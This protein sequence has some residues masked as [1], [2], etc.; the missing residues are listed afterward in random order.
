MKT[1]SPIKRLILVSL[2][3]VLPVVYSGSIVA[4]QPDAGVTAQDILELLKHEGVITPEQADKVANIANNRRA[5]ESQAPVEYTDDANKDIPETP[6][7]GVTRIPYIPKY[8]RNEIR[9]TVRLGLREDVL[10]DVMTQARNES[11][12]VPGTNPDWTKAIKI[13]GDLRTRYQSDQFSDGNFTQYRDYNAI[14]ARGGIVPAGIDAFLNTTENR[15]RLRLRL[16]LG[17]DAQVTQGVLASVRLTTGGDNPVSSNQTLG[18]YGS[19][20]QLGI[21]RAYIRFNS[22]ENDYDLYFGRMPNPWMTTSQLVWDSDLNFDGV[23]YSYFF[24]RSDSMFDGERQFDPF[25]TL[26][27]FPLQEVKLSSKDK[28]LFGAQTGFEYISNSQNKFKLALAYYNFLNI[29]GQQN[30]PDSIDMNFTAPPYVQKGNTMFDISNSTLDPELQ[31][32]ALLPDYKEVNLSVFYD[33]ANFSPIHVIVSADYVKNIGFDNS[34]IFSRVGATVNKKT[35]GYDVG[36]KVGWPTVIQ[37]GNWNASLHYRYLERD[38]VIDAFTDSDFHMGGTDGKGYKLAYSYGI[39]ENTWL[40]V[41][42]ISAD[43]IDGPPLGVS[44]VFV[45]VNA[46]F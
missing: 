1:M 35:K 46:K 42:L 5:K 3:M 45:D 29:S 34:R 17:I 38:A 27:A 36:L 24:N 9:D 4:A 8:I 12:G 23:A 33:I 7:A 10:D 2:S 39:E 41:M 37:R 31:L 20:Y 6:P 26:G 30:S 11:W 13:K 43:E 21:D 14:N 22:L 32:Y 44:T 28:W 16:R 25:L 18:G 40:D 15:D 19:R